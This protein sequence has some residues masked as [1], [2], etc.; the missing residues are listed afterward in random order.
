MLSHDETYYERRRP[1]PDL[2][3]WRNIMRFIWNTEKRAFLDRNC[4]EWSKNVMP[5]VITLINN[6]FRIAQVGLFYLCFFGVLFSLFAFKMWI[7]MSYV[8]GLDKPY[9]QR[10]N[11]LTRSYLTAGAGRYT[12]TSYSG[13]S[14]PGTGFIPNILTPTSS[15]I[16]WISQSSDKGRPEKYMQIITDF[17]LGYHRNASEYSDSCIEGKPRTEFDGRPCFFDINRLGICGKFPYGYTVPVQPCVLVKFNKVFDWIP[18]YYE[19]VSELPDKMPDWLRNVIRNSTEYQIWLSCEGSN[20]VDK[21]HIGLI[22]YI[23][24][25]GF[26]VEYFPYTG[27]TGFLSPIVALRFLNL[28]ANR[29]IT[30]EC[31]AWAKKYSYTMDFQIMIEE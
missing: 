15:P 24:K 31:T 20:N 19:K 13:L 22:E 6:S 4:R 9:I 26:S 11:L 7:T 30:V 17:L 5:T 10:A 2:G 3:P 28:T 14:A 27:Q 25:S 12:R 8:A 16:I 21:E 23:P 29:L 18:H 1:Q